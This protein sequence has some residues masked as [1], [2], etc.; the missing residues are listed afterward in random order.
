MQIVTRNKTQPIISNR[1]GFILIM[2][3]EIAAK[4]FF[5]QWTGLQ[6]QITAP[7]HPW[8]FVITFSV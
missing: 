7:S 1:L 2:F 8:I 5:K 4:S 3:I 6:V